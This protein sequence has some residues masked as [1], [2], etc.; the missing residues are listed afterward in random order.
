MRTI[1]VRPVHSAAFEK[2]GIILLDRLSPVDLFLDQTIVLYNH[3]MDIPYPLKD[4]PDNEQLNLA[5]IISSVIQEL[6]GPK[7]LG[8]FSR[9][10]NSEASWNRR[11]KSD[12]NHRHECT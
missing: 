5:C 12:W 8:P 4:V 2:L 10:G 9:H 11:D 7:R 3:I 6:H 1:Q